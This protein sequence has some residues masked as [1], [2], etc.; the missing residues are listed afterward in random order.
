MKLKVYLHSFQKKNNM[1]KYTNIIIT[2]WMCLVFIMLAPSKAKAQAIEADYQSFD[3]RNALLFGCDYQDPITRMYI[4]ILNVRGGFGNYTV[5]PAANSDVSSST[6]TTGEGFTFYFT[7]Q[8]KLDGLIDFT[9]SDGINTYSLDSLV[10]TQIELLPF[11]VCTAPNYKCQNNIEHIDMT[12]PVTVYN[13]SDYIKSNSIILSPST[14]T[15]YLSG[16]FIELQSGFEVPPNTGFFADI[17]N[18]GP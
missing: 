16:N 5:I 6:I 1:H 7:E 8:D 3:G 12:V 9:I 2:L 4:N 18:C 14:T 15:S 13:T 10:K 17:E 11:F